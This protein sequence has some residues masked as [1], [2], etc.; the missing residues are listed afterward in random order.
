MDGFNM[1]LEKIV[2]IQQFV[3]IFI[4]YYILYDPWPVIFKAYN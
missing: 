4:L 1:R 2:A 3:V